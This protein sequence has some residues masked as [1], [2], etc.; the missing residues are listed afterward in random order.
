MPFALLDIQRE[1][2]A[3]AWDYKFRIM[4]KAVEFHQRH[5]FPE[6]QSEVFMAQAFTRLPVTV[7]IS[8]QMYKEVKPQSNVSQ[9]KTHFNKLH[10][11]I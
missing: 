6:S 10:P 9:N 2:Q 8:C 11:Q 7:S 5:F 1:S 3:Y 4:Y